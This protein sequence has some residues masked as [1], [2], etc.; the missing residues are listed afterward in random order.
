MAPSQRLSVFCVVALGC[1]AYACLAKEHDHADMYK[2]PAK[3][4]GH[5]LKEDA[6]GKCLEEPEEVPRL[7]GIAV[8][9]YRTLAIEAEE[10]HFMKTLSMAPLILEIDDFLT[11]KE[12]DHL[13]KMAKD[14]G[15]EDTINSAATSPKERI[16]VSDFNSDGQLDTNEMRI[17]LEDNFDVYLC[18][19]DV[20]NVYKEL[21]MDTNGDNLISKAELD[22]VTLSNFRDFVLHYVNEHPVCQPRRSKEAK[23][24]INGTKDGVFAKIEQ[25]I[26]R[27]LRLRNAAVETDSELLVMKFEQEGHE[28]AHID[29]APILE[30]L[31]CCHKTDSEV[32]RDCRY[33][34]VQ[35]HLSNVEEGGEAAFPVANND[36]Y[37]PKDLRLGNKRNLRKFCEESNLRVT[38]KKG[39]A[40]IWYNHFPSGDTGEVGEIDDRTW[41]GQCAVTKGEKWLAKLWININTYVEPEPEPEEDDVEETEEDPKPE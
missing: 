4:E 12:C 24:A 10:T 27:A 17:S 6:D 31:P 13:I 2:E 8:G 41:N 35:L 14:Q 1:F 32:C 26:L 20:L 39:K 34:T 15:L 18:E 28:N 11:S 40:V 38:P 9:F 7:D 19:E 3:G 25:R 33:A 5:C 30:R 22:E 37:S 36:T 29:S 16:H 21:R 23:I